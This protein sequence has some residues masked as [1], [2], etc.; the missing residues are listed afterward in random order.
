M[1]R[2]QKSL[3]DCFKIPK[4]FLEKLVFKKIVYSKYIEP[5]DGVDLNFFIQDNTNIEGYFQSIFYFKDNSELIRKELTPK[6]QYIVNAEKKLSE[7]KK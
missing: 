2:G 1:L 3:L 6:D 7:I 5:D 4:E